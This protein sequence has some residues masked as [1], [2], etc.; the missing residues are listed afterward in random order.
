MYL[1]PGV[2]YIL[3]CQN[4]EVFGQLKQVECTSHNEMMLTV[5]IRCRDA[6]G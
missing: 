1:A 5:G 4:A 2:E 6:G 3:Y